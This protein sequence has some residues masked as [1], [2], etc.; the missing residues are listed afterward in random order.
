MQ[1]AILAKSAFVMLHLSHCICHVAFVKLHLS[2]C[3]C[4]IA[5]VTLHL[6]Y[7]TCHISHATLHLSNLSNSIC[8]T[9]FVYFTFV[10][11]LRSKPNDQAFT[12]TARLYGRRW[13]MT[14][15][16]RRPSMEDNLL[17]KTTYDRR[18]HS[19]ENDLRCKTSY[20]GRKLL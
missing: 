1:S 6:L 11:R 17:W 10:Q 12:S 20:D 3:S 4:Y 9:V 16:G 13:K 8:Y 5:L 2:Q 18:Q 14:F 19:M 15:N 7:C